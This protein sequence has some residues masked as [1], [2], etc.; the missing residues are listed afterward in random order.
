MLSNTFL[1]KIVMEADDE[2]LHTI[3]DD[4]SVFDIIIRFANILWTGKLMWKY[5]E[6]SANI[7]FNC[8]FYIFV[9][10][11]LYPCHDSICLYYNEN[12]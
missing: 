12:H 6:Y 8:Y 7:T 9:E 4:D 11:F 1:S 10:G 5:T 3:N 2:F